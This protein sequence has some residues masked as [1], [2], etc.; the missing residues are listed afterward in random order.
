MTLLL[1]ATACD[2]AS[3]EHNTAESRTL[4]ERAPADPASLPNVLLITLDTTRADHLGCFGYPKRTSTHIDRLAADGTLFTRA[5][6]TAAVTNTAHASIFT[7]LLPYQHNVRLLLDKRQSVLPDEHNTISE[8]YRAAGAR[9][10]AFVSAVPASSDFGLNQGFE[11]FDE[12]FDRDGVI[13]QR[14]AEETVDAALRW[15]GSG[16]APFFCWVHLF[17]PH[18]PKLRPPFEICD[19]FR[20]ADL[21]DDEAKLRAI[22]DA[23]IYYMDL[24]IG[25]L[26]EYLEQTAQRDRTLIVLVSDHGEGLGDHNW[27]QHGIIYQEQV[28]VPL[29]LCGPGVPRGRKVDELVSTIDILPTIVGLT[30]IAAHLPA[31]LEGRDLRPLL[32]KGGQITPTYVYCDA[33]NMQVYTHLGTQRRKLDKFY[34]IMDDRWKLIH[35]QLRPEEGEL[36]DLQRDPRELDNLYHKET[37]VRDRLTKELMRRD[38]FTDL[39]TGM[40]DMDAKLLEKLKSLGYVADESAP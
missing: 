14:S 31:D 37:V 35:H 27:W 19:L 3:G 26:L 1:S 34:S 28:H 2:R 16:G 17:D 15:L 40:Y 23:E 6:S 39:V 11:V 20:P 8:F 33:T 9:T 25:R 21:S 32:S 22:Y 7:G 12:N 29:I 36:Y 24:H 4:L 5:M 10:A 13:N 38:P 18:D 30:G